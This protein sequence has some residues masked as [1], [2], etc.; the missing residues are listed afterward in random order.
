MINER[1]IL[2]E[3]KH[4]FTL[5]L[6]SAFQ[7]NSRLF[8]LMDFCQNGDLATQISKLGCFPEA[9]AQFYLSCVLLALADLHKRDIVFRDLKPQNVLLDEKGYAILGDF[10]LSKKGVVSHFEGAHSFCGSLAYLSPEVAKKS[11]YGKAVDWYLLGVLF[12]EMLFGFPP[13][14][15]DE[16]EKIIDNILKGTLKIPKKITPNA[17]S[18]LIGVFLASIPI[19]IPCFSLL[20]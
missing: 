7:T 16:T 19:N 17:K 18:L 8:L 13:Y 11:Q 6:R 15:T 9:K 2:K 4:P 12:Y 5:G 1:S 10:G 14:A 3:N 20:K